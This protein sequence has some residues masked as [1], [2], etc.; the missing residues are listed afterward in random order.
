MRG[1]DKLAEFMAEAY[2]DVTHPEKKGYGKSK[3]RKKEAKKKRRKHSK[4]EIGR[5]SEEK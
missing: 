4:E 5:E 1:V 3:S 2:G